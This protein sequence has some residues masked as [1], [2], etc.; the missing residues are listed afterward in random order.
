MNSKSIDAGTLD[1]APRTYDTVVIGGGVSGLIFARERALAGASVLV[2]EADDHVGGAVWSH[3]LAS[4]ESHT[5][6][7]AFAIGRGAMVELVK[8]LGLEDRMVTPA[9][10]TSFIVSDTRAYPSPKNAIMGLPSNGCAPDV[11]RAL[12]VWAAIR[13]WCERFIPSSVATDDAISIGEF[14]RARYGRR[15]VERLVAPIIQGVHSADPY[16]LELRSVMPQLPALVREHGNSSRAIEALLRERGKRAGSG[17][18][19]YSLRPSMAELP[20]ALARESQARGATVETSARARRLRL[21]PANPAP[22]GISYLNARDASAEM[23]EVRAR[24]LVLAVSPETTRE[25]LGDAAPEIARLVPHIPATPVRLAS[26]VLDNPRLDAKPRGNGVLVAPGTREI[27]AKAMTH[28]SAKWE[29]IGEAARSIAPGRHVVRLS[30]G[31][32]DDE[33]LPDVSEF[34]ELAVRD[35]ARI[36]GLDSGELGLVEW[37][38]TDWVGTMRQSGPGHSARMNE[39]AAALERFSQSKAPLHLTGAWRAGNGL[40]AI[41]RFTRALAKHTDTLRE[42]THS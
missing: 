30:Y 39:L 41:T 34:P 18:A 24:E 25:L 21:D 35:A 8:D 33:A 13:A 31:R 11:R 29:H 36:L 3:V 37:A 26:L 17:A 6:A 32:G 38:I 20:R 14:A 9:T 42:G 1:A 28:A 12:G 7:E 22:W 5:G 10:G 16:S 27:R 19:V 15:V 40:E 23:R 2:L 4:V